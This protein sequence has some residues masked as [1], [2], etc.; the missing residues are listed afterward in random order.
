MLHRLLT[1]MIET[2]IDKYGKIRGVEMRK[3]PIPDEILQQMEDPKKGQK[4]ENN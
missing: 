3:F 1:E 2:Y 4:K